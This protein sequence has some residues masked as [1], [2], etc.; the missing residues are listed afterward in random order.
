MNENDKC[1]TAGCGNSRDKKNRRK[2]CQS[3]RSQQYRQA[4]PEVATYHS[5]KSKAKHRDISWSMTRSEW[6]DLCINTGYLE[7]RGRGSA[8]LTLDR[9]IPDPYLGYTYT[10]TQVITQQE[11]SRKGQVEKRNMKGWG[12]KGLG[13]QSSDPF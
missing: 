10:N 7:L 2:I 5:R 1:A 12:K 3:C 4:N 8:D 6:H 11:N 13:K 9:K